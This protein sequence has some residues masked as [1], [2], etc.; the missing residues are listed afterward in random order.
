MRLRNPVIVTTLVVSLGACAAHP[1]AVEKTA[2]APAEAPRATAGAP[3]VD[4]SRHLDRALEQLQA[5]RYEAARPELEAALALEPGHWGAAGL[6]AQLDADPGRE[7]GGEH[8]SYTVQPGDSLSRLAKRHLGDRYKFVILARYNQLDNPGRLMAGQTIRIPGTAPA[9]PAVA[10]KAAASAAER[11]PQAALAA[12]PGGGCAAGIPDLEQRMAQSPTASD[13][14]RLVGC[15]S[16]QADALAAAGEVQGAQALLQKALVLDRSNA[17]VA[18]RHMALSGAV[19]AGQLYQ[20]GLARL[21]DGQ[22]DE[23][24]AAFGQVLAQQPGHAAARARLASVNGQLADRY[25]QMALSL[26]ERELVDSA[27]TL[28]NKTLELKPDHAEALAYV[29]KVKARR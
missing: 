16:E 10:T 12:E 5:G 2:Q 17:E 28:W 22:L 23:A 29:D 18:Q 20:Q 21:Q 13:R 3:G 25:H 11:V 19:R 1:P 6:L 24:A 26:Y 27:L 7:L 15:Y 8:F 4:A 9:T 14:E